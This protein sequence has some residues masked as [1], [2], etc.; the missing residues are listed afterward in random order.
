MPREGVELR[1]VQAEAA[2][3][4]RAMG[5]VQVDDPRGIDVEDAGLPGG[6]YEDVGTARF[7]QLDIRHSGAG[8]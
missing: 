8:G 5:L 1:N 6:F 4:Q 7:R 2:Q 3:Q